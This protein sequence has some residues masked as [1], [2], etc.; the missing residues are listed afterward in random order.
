MG[1]GLVL[2]VAL[3]GCMGGDTSSSSSSSA[4]TRGDCSGQS[5]V[6]TWRMITQLSSGYRSSDET[7]T[8]GSDCKMTLSQCGTQGWAA[9]VDPLSGP[10]PIGTSLPTRVVQYNDVTLPLCI[11]KGTWNCDVSHYMANF[12]GVGIYEVLSFSCPGA[13]AQSGV[14][15]LIY[16][17]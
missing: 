3:S 12:I 11:T 14:T 15:P 7:L 9:T 10:L 13:Y 4:S 16:V 17:K 5:F 6:G 2:L 1:F 8:I